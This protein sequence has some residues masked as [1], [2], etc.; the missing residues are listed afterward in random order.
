MGPITAS[1]ARDCAVGDPALW[2]R[3]LTDPATGT[4][5]EQSEHEYRPSRRLD[6]TIRSRDVTCRFPGCR[7]AATGGSDL[8]HTVPWPAGPTAATNLASLCRRHHRLK[9]SPGWSV[10]QHEGGILQWTTPDGRKFATEPW[11]YDDPRGP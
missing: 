2:R 3:L 9:H 8:D 10:E 6:R 5:V 1:Q 11:C 4:L 7:R